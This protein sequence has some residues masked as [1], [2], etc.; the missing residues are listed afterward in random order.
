M[1]FVEETATTGLDAEGADLNGAGLR[2]GG[3]S[4]GC[5]RASEECQPPSSS[6]VRE[7]VPVALKKANVRVR[8][9]LA[10]L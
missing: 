2:R 4:A 5:S 10:D 7:G 1:R 8:V 9:W 3:G 6:V